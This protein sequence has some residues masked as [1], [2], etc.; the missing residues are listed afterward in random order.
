MRTTLCLLLSTVLTF[1]AQLPPLPSH[2]LPIRLDLKSFAASSTG[3]QTSPAPSNSSVSVT[4]NKSVVLE[5]SA[6]VKRISIANPEIAEAVAASTTEVLLNGK[7]PGD[8]SLILWDQKGGRT[9]FDVHVETNDNKLGIVREQLAAELPGQDVALISEGGNVILR[10][11]V[12]DLVSADRALAIAS[13]LGKVINLLN[14]LVPPSD[15]QILLKVRFVDI[16]RTALSQFGA[17]FFSTGSAVM[18]GSLSTGQFAGPPSFDYS[19]T[20]PLVTIPDPLNIFVFRNDLNLGGYIKA[21]QEK[22]LAQILAEPNLL[23]LSGR[24][25]NFLAGGEFPFPMLQGGGA[26]VGQITIQFKEFGIRLKFRPTVTPRGTI[27][28]MVNPEVSALDSAN[29]LTVQGYT[30][31]GLDT[32]RVRTEVELK[33]GQS[34]M[35][36]G[37]L[38]NRL[39]QTISKIPGLANIPLLGKLFES[40]GTQR[41]NTELMVVVTPEIVKPIEPGAVPTLEMPQPFMKG[42]T[43]TPPQNPVVDGKT[44]STLRIVKTVP[45][46]VLKMAM[47]NE[48]DADDPSKPASG[49]DA[50][51]SSMQ[52]TPISHN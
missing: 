40:R 26:G 36:A 7:T 19:Q 8:T 6:G 5:N 4:V 9:L 31:P 32:R 33:D 50:P 24:E 42:I 18:P 46:E 3:Q 27:H 30:I 23:T 43:T 16:D 39:T 20:P 17:N 41:N 21:L 48:S 44:G 2:T 38:D 15:P 13:P 10:G 52:P 49:Q 29:G 12:T 14:V 51:A 45:V 11:T 1:G 34:F 22:Q 35:I 47:Q 37:L 25:A 28:L